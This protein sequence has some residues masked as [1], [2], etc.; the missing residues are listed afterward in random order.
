[1]GYEVILL[2]GRNTKQVFENL[3]YF[4]VI[5]TLDLGKCTRSNILLLPWENL[6]NDT[7]FEF[8]SP[9]GDNDQSIIEDRYGNRMR[10]IP[11]DDVIAALEK[12]V[13][14]DNY[15]PAVWAISLLNKMREDAISDESF[16]VMLY[17]H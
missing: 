16:T 1:M 7:T 15:R 17:G 13:R 8:F 10:P 4:Q 9:T 3:T 2:I 5:A 6:K 12:D 11:L 14:R